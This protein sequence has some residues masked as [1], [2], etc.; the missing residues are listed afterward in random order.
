MVVHP[1]IFSR[2]ST[3][4]GLLRMENAG[5]WAAAARTFEVRPLGV[6]HWRDWSW[7]R[8]QQL[9]KFRLIGLIYDMYYKVFV[10]L[11]CLV[12]NE[13]MVTEPHCQHNSTQQHREASHE[14]S[15]MSNTPGNK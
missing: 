10:R 9:N 8:S 7:G 6:P 4:V 12:S 2:Q 13:R 3:V 5:S 15:K 11:H 14:Q 1:S